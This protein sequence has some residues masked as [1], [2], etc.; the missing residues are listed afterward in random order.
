MNSMTTELL[1]LPVLECKICGHKWYPRSPKLPT[2]C[3]NVKCAS[4]NWN[5]TEFQRKSKRRSGVGTES[6]IEPLAA[7][8]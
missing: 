5:R 6:T 7:T 2:R 1:N 8:A 3:S 4:P